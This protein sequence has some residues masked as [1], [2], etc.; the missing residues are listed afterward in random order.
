MEITAILLF[1]VAALPVFL[2]AFYIYKKDK[3]KE[4]AGLLAKL[5]FAA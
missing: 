5:F 2:I 3:D 1:I 4:P